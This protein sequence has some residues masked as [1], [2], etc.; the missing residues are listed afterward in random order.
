MKT[1]EN[2]IF[3]V[4]SG[5]GY[6]TINR[7]DSLN[8]LN[9]AVF[10]ELEI[11]LQE[12]RINNSIQAV[13][14]TGEGKAFVAG[15]DISLMSDLSAMEGRTWTM[16]GQNVFNE[17]E[18][19]EKPVIAAV[20]GYALGGGCEL[21][22]ACDIIFASDKAKFGQPEVNLGIIPGYG[23]TQ[24]LPRIIGEKNAKYLIY[25]GEI[26]DAAEAFRMGLVQKVFPAETLLEEAEKFANKVMTKA[27]IGLKMA[28]VAIRNGMNVDLRTGIAFEAEAYAGAF[29]SDDRIEGM[30]AFL[31]K[32]K[33]SFQNK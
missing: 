22:M 31:E 10:D 9:G 20:N 1:F 4:K 32:R 28:K 18:A 8:A 27:P 30:R 2:I 12:I 5:I 19:I 26:I 3:E 14:I 13:I 6:I 21:A 24:R 15:A 23:G 7:P 25:S 17:L 29:N 11:A 16:R 33:P